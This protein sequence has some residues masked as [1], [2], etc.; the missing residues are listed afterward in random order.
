MIIILGSEGKQNEQN[1]ETDHQI[2]HTGPR[3]LKRS[4]EGYMK[5]PVPMEAKAGEESVWDYPR[6]PALEPVG[7]E[8]V[9]TFNGVEVARTSQ[10]FRV[11][12]TSHPPNY[13]FPPEDVNPELLK[14]G[15]L[16]TGCE[17]KGK[18]KYYHLEVGDKRSE[19]A[20]WYYDKPNPRF[21]KIKDYIAFYPARVD[22][23][24]VNG[25]LVEPQPGE[26]YGGWITEKIKGLFKGI[27]GSWGW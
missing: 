27:D 4:K 7:E 15:A 10:G 14:P 24:T 5:R 17:W 6:P 18:G 26:F 22:E 19:N 3:L 12:E 9:V 23:C 13:Y 1:P 25:E 21:E 8:L 11:L 16:T 2:N 20:A